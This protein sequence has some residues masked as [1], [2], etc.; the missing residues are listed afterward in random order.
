MSD[1]HEASVPPSCGSL[2]R[3]LTE[4]GVQT[5]NRTAQEGTDSHCQGQSLDTSLKQRKAIWDLGVKIP[6]SF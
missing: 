2:P 6:S 4:V 3:R 1:A 5:E